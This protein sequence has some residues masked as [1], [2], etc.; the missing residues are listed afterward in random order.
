MTS[1]NYI[2]PDI[3]SIFHI[4]PSEKLTLTSKDCNNNIREALFISLVA[5]INKTN[6]GRN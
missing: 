6:I 1:I 2:L 4:L 5:G 3:G